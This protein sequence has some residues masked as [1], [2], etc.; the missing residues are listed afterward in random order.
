MFFHFSA[1]NTYKVGKPTTLMIFSRM[2]NVNRPGMVPNQAITMADLTAGGYR[3]R[4][5][6]S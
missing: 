1:K 5:F 3:V 4:L 6:Q 2:V